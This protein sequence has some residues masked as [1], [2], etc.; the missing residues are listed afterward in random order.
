MNHL[1]NNR[2]R[3]RI[4]PGKMAGKQQS[5]IL[6]KILSWLK[7][8]IWGAAEY[9]KIAATQTYLKI[10]GKTA[11]LIP[12]KKVPKRHQTNP[13]K[14]QVTGQNGEED[15]WDPYNV[16]REREGKKPVN[17]SMRE[18]RKST[19]KDLHAEEVARRASR[20]PQIKKDV[21]MNPELVD[22][23]SEWEA[24]VK[25]DLAQGKNIRPTLEANPELDADTIMDKI[26]TEWAARA[27]QNQMGTQELLD[28]LNS[29]TDSSTETGTSNGENADTGLDTDL[30]RGADASAA[31]GGDGGGPDGSAN[32][33]PT[34]AIHGGSLPGVDSI[35]ISTDTTTST[36]TGSSVSPDISTDIGSGDAGSG[37]GVGG[38]DVGGGDI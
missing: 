13:S 17:Q 21:L 33:V 20:N 7:N 10:K 26:G 18:G 12:E 31:T 25:I 36:G 34:S 6:D 37:S 2:P 5:N 19:L 9:I 3:H 30:D 15:A 1:T 24:Q 22:A 11:E 8:K 14:K 4:T 38:G 27:G 29:D 23:G 28:A 16:R 32:G 35:D